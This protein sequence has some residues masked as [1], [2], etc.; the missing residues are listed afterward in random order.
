MDNT[1]KHKGIRKTI[2]GNYRVKPE[3]QGK[4]YFLGTYEELKFA[5]KAIDNFNRKHNIKEETTTFTL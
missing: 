5:I 2:R 3:Y 1:S 4:K